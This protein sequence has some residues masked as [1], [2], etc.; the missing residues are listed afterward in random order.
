MGEWSSGWPRLNFGVS[1]FALV[2]TSTHSRNGKSVRCG[3]HQSRLSRGGELTTIA[4]RNRELSVSQRF[5]FHQPLSLLARMRTAIDI[6]RGRLPGALAMFKADD[7]S[8]SVHSGG[9]H[10]NRCQVVFWF[11]DDSSACGDAYRAIERIYE[12][13]RE[14]CNLAARCL[15]GQTPTS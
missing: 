14:Q 12:M 5:V 11:D 4:T 13:N 7:I 3:T 10:G 2:G 8:I 9:E 1:C 15:S 6:M